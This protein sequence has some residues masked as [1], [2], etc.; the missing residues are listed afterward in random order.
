MRNREPVVLSIEVRN[1]GNSLVEVKTLSLTERTNATVARPAIQIAASSR[2]NGF[3]LQNLGGIARNVQFGF[4]FVSPKSSTCQRPG[5]TRHRYPGLTVIDDR[6]QI[7]DLS[8]FTKQPNNLAGAEENKLTRVVGMLTYEWQDGSH[9][10]TGAARLCTNISLRAEQ[11]T[12]REQDRPDFDPGQFQPAVWVTR[13][14]VILTFDTHPIVLD[15]NKENVDG[16]IAAKSPKSFTF[17]LA[18]NQSSEHKF[19]IEIEFTGG[20]KRPLPTPVKLWY[21]VPQGLST[22]PITLVKT[23]F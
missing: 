22:A 2:Q 10:K 4:S 21:F 8:D 7:I 14:P 18:A 1:N 11:I 12:R 5:S 23:A 16:K 6:P 3:T 17:P 15:L 20:E 9:R 19:T 13:N